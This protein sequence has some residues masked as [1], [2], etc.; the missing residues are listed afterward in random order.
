MSEEKLI[1]P[2]LDGFV[3]GDAISEH[4]GI[5][6]YP[7]MREN[8]DEKYIV[9]VISIPASQ[10][11]LDA[12]LLT[13]A[14]QD[15]AGATEYFKELSDGVVRDAQL[16][17]QLAKLEGF[18]P[19]E[20]WQVAPMQDNKLGYEVYLVSPY[21]RSLEK[22]LR[23]NTM[24]HLGAVNL[25]LDLCAALSMCRRAGFLYVALKPGNIFL[26]GEREYKIGDLGF[27]KLNSLKYTSMPAQYLSP[28]TPPELHDALATLN[29]TVDI[30]AVGMILYMIYNNGVLPYET[31]APN[32]L[33]PA[34]MN[35]DYEMAEIIA[36]ACHPNPRHRY[37]TPIEMGQALKDYMQRNTINNT[38]IVPPAADPVEEA[39]AEDG[40]L[41]DD[42][43]SEPMDAAYEEIP[44]APAAEIVPEPAEQPSDDL[45]FLEDLV[46]DETAP[47]AESTDTD[48]DAEMSD[49]VSSILAQADELVK[50]AEEEAPADEPQQEEIPPVEDELGIQDLLADTDPNVDVKS[51][52]S[53]T[54]D[55][56]EDDDDDEGNEEEAAAQEQDF[57]ADTGRKKKKGRGWIA[58]VVIVLIFALLGAG[59]YYFYQNYYLLPIDLMN[60]SCVEDTITVSLTTD[61]DQS[62][63]T[64]VCTD[65]YGNT[66]SSKLTDGQAVFTELNPDTQ[67]KFTVEAEGFHQVSGS[68]YST[69]ST[70][71][72]TNI[73]EFTAKTGTED[74]SVMLNFT[75]DGPETQD[76]VVEYATEGEETRSLSFT[77]HMVTVNGLT[78]GKTYTFTLVPPPGTE[79]WLVGTNTLEFTASRIIVAEDVS[80]VSCIDGVL[81]AQWN[82]PEGAEV[83]SWTVRCYSDTGYDQTVTVSEASVEFSDIDTTKAYTVEVWASGMTQSTRAYVTANPSTITDINVDDTD[84]AGL[85][86]TWNF[87]GT[88]PEGGWLLMYSLDGSESQEVITCTGAEATIEQRIPKATYD[89]TIKAAD[90]STVFGGTEQYTCPAAEN[91]NVNGAKTESIT[92]NLLTTPE[93][94]DWT[95]KDVSEDDFITAF[96][97]DAKASVLLTNSEKMSYP[98]TA[99][100]IL[101]VIRN[102]EG[103]VQ[104]KLLRT[105][106]TPWNT[107]WKNKNCT[108]DIPV[109]PSETGDYTLEIYFNGALAATKDFKVTAG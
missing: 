62:L 13:G 79:Q 85:K 105:V 35:A 68:Y 89:L 71:K 69:Y 92:M 63:L 77:G 17:R 30:Y 27:V 16:L 40:N 31:K 61:V 21:K 109:M 54:E 26:T 78:V 100:E 33:L 24:T 6:C 98:N 101:Y 29:P 28:F 42:A 44:E 96:P 76:W 4:D 81:T 108:L 39:P 73:V 49:E 90:G 74:G 93:T 10:K 104:P 106:T 5:R 66:K 8:S 60:I 9:K 58:I 15:A 1:S 2:L 97:V 67:Y 23:R 87:S 36:K 86:V 99:T 37:Q 51:L 14:F 83:D 46:A 3:M 32:K 84:P 34:P 91:L 41:S 38:P 22:H 95:H 48:T 75:V 82:V 103:K 50:P 52:L 20:G 80:I 43:I 88:A 64:I 59:G 57:F 72:Q 25:G 12:L 70:G 7:A 47:G 107:I 102:A 11:R 55:V 45:A 56:D 19:Y 94:E 53:H 65:S 18:L